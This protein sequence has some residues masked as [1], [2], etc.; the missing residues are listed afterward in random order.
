MAEKKNEK[1]DAYDF[2]VHDCTREQIKTVAHT[3]MQMAVPVQKH[4]WDPEI[5]LL[6]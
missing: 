5:L 2:T 6:W 3:L 1:I 4:W